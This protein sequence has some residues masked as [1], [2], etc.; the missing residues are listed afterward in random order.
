M[1]RPIEKVEEEATPKGNAGEVRARK[2]AEKTRGKNNREQRETE[3]GYRSEKRSP[4]LAP[5]PR[6]RG[7]KPSENP[8]QNALFRSAS[9]ASSD[10][11]ED[12]SSEEEEPNLSLGEERPDLYHPDPAPG[13]ATGRRERR[14]AVKQIV[15]ALMQAGMHVDEII[16]HTIARYPGATPEEAR[17]TYYQTLRHW[18]E[19]FEA[20]QPRAKAEQIARLRKDLTRMRTA[21]NPNWSVINKHEELYSRVAGTQAPVKLAVDVGATVRQSVLAVV[22]SLTEAEQERMIQEQLRLEERA[23]RFPLTG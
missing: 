1:R 12:G 19:Q 13:T 4:N 11:E 21:H 2:G 7:A 23:G 3:E 20:D 16:E 15:V 5:N 6:A 18:D 17:A 22:A 14:H 9:H 10:V 8:G